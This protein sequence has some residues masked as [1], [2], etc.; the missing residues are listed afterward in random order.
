M[1]KCKLFT[2]YEGETAGLPFWSILSF[3]DHLIAAWSI[4]YQNYLPLA[5]YKEKKKKL[6]IIPYK[7]EAD[8][9]ISTRLL[10]IT[11]TCHVEPKKICECFPSGSV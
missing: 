8:C 1:L 3:Y 5:T 2:V 6:D 7:H 11:L 4:K 9:I 10:S